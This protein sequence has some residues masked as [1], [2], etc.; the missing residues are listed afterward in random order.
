MF[1]IFSSQDILGMVED[2]LIDI[3]QVCEYLGE[4][5]G[6]YQQGTFLF[7]L[8]NMNAKIGYK[9]YIYFDTAF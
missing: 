5:F 7:Q 6:K 4:I 2:F 1:T 3:P 8:L 9:V